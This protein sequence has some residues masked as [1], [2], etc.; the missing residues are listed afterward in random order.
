MTCP[1]IVNRSKTV[2]VLFK[3]FILTKSYIDAVLLTT[4]KKQSSRNMALEETRKWM[5]KM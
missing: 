5:K 3:L 2:F 1:W 4:R